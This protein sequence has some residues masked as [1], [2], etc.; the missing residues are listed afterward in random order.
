MPY[1]PDE[2]YAGS[3]DN[4]R[5]VE[6]QSQVDEVVGIMRGNMEKVLERDAKLGDLEDKSETLAEGSARFQMTSKKLKNAMWWQDKKWWCYLVIVILVIIV[7]AVLASA[8]WKN[9]GNDN[10]GGGGGGGGNDTT[11]PPATTQQRRA[12]NVLG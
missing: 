11:K 12:R 6:A 5:L 1:D 2:S 10:G 7:I 4:R 9:S 8:P 3:G